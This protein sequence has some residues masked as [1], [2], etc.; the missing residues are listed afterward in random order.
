MLSIQRL[1]SQTNSAFYLHRKIGRLSSP[2]ELSII[3]RWS[4][5]RTPGPASPRIVKQW[6]SLSIIHLGQRWHRHTVQNIT[7]AQKPSTI[8][9][10]ANTLMRP[11]KPTLW[12]V[13]TQHY[14]RLIRTTDGSDVE[15]GRHRFHFD[16]GEQQLLR[17]IAERFSNE[18]PEIANV[19][20]LARTHRC[21]KHCDATAWRHT[22][23]INYKLPTLEIIY[24]LYIRLA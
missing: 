19:S 8:V 4:W 14:V 23:A 16:S 18:S 5:C 22:L 7:G 24:G 2:P 6:V 3:S 21:L 1:L 11:A 12:A 10:Y 17:L 15:I 13:R 9:C 20:A